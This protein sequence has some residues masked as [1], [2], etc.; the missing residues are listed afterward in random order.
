L[1]VFVAAFDNERQAGAA[2]EDFR[3]TDPDGSIELVD[4]VVIVRGADGKVRIEEAADAGDEKW[5]KRGAVAGTLVGLIFS[6]SIIGTAVNGGVGG[7]IWGKCAT[8]A[9]EMRT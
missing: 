6:P 5:A 7:G 4:A 3:T 1:Q 9:F 8:K 2:L